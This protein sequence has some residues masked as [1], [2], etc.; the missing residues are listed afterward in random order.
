MNSLHRTV[1]LPTKEIIML[2]FFEKFPMMQLRET[3][4]LTKSRHV[5]IRL[6]LTG[7]LDPSEPEAP[8]CYG[9]SAHPMPPKRKITGAD[10]VNGNAKLRRE[11]NR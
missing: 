9:F 6:I 3:L 4:Y 7:A 5:T 10:N 2:I 8:S 1:Q 11:V